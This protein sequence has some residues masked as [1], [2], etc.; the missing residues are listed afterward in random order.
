MLEFA[1]SIKVLDED[2]GLLRTVFEG[3][4]VKVV[5]L[6]GEVFEGKIDKPTKS[7]FQ[8]I[9]EGESGKRIFALETVSFEFED[10]DEE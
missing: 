7:E 1:K 5:D 3:E 4:R 2:G 6:A 9:I 10:E 8:L